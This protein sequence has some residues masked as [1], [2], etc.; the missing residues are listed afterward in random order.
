MKQV[1]LNQMKKFYHKNKEGNMEV[2][3]T[4]PEVDVP[5][6]QFVAVSVND[7]QIAVPSEMAEPIEEMNVP[8]VEMAVPVNDVVLPV[9]ELAVLVNE[10]VPAKRTRRPPAYFSSR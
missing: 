1:H 10:V 5:D 7:N 9:E 4:E 2:I 8:I 6:N 3:M